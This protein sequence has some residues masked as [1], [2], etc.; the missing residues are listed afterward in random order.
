[1]SN[2]NCRNQNLK[3]FSKTIYSERFLSFNS[4]TDLTKEEGASR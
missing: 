1:M 2:E 4:T 3:K